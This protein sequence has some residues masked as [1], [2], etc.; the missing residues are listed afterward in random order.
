MGYAQDTPEICL[1]G[2]GDGPEMC[3]DWAWGP[4]ICPRVYKNC[5]SWVEGVLK[6]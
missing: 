4:G 6:K 5:M 3:Q 1:R 2:A